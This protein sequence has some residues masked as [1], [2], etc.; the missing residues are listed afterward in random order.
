MELASRMV[1]A[2]TRTVEAPEKAKSPKVGMVV[3]V[4]DAKFI[5]GFIPSLVEK[6]LYPYS[7]PEFLYF[8]EDEILLSADQCVRPVLCPKYP[9]KMP[10]YAGYAEVINAGKTVQNEDQASARMLTLVQQGHEAEEA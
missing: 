3:D 7:R 6:Q 9:S 5:G 8:S 1:S 4:S 10:L 2:M